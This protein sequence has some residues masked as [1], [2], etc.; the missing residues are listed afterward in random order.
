MKDG[1]K[2]YPKSEQIIIFDFTVYQAKGAKQSTQ[3]HEEE[4]ESQLPPDDDIPF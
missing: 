2:V 1:E 4:E 3:P